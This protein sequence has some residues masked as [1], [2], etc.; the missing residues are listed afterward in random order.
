[1]TTE[2][3]GYW[4]SPWPGEDGGPARR[5]TPRRLELADESIAGGGL[6]LAPG[7][8]LHAHHRDVMA[9]T[10]AVLREPGEVFVLGHTLGPTGTI[11]WLERIDP[12]SLE[13]VERSPD[14]PGGPFWPGGV[15]AHANGSLYVT[16]GRWCHRLGPDCTVI[17]SRE[18]PRDRPYNSL[19]VLPD[20]HLVMK[21]IGGGA[22]AGPL[23]LPE[24]VRGSELV[25]L[26]PEGLAVVDRHELDEG[27]VARLSM[28]TGPDA[29][30]GA[31][32]VVGVESLRRLVWDPVAARLV[33]DE[34]FTTRY[35]LDEGQG[36]GWD[37]VLADGSA[38]LLDD[39]AGTEGFGPSL[40]GKGVATA[41]LCLWRVTPGSDGGRPIVDRFEVCGE[42]GGVIANPPAV[43]PTRRLALGYDSGN[44]VV[45][46]WRYGAAGEGGERLW[47]RRLDQAGHPLLFP[48]TGEVV[49]G[50]FDH[51]TGQEQVVVVDVESGEVRARV[52]TGSPLQSVLFPAPGWSDDLYTCTFTT[53]SRVHR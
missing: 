50:D 1:M 44:G 18:L 17:A 28:D 3:D 29:A 35:R 21:D 42:P 12:E 6:G 23:A 49:L 15:A 38:W 10:M 27:S 7:A 43:D 20:G 33:P 48:D 53:L 39:G 46:A 47:S 30:G 22:D 45:T 8:T 9:V 52:A 25:V 14:L 34:A 2:L 19:V 26:E 24:G 11:S 16:Y 32:Y 31:V 5:Q 40:R 41:P 51:E 4:P 36:F 37:V 13:P